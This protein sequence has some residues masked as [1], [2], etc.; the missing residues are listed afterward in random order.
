MSSV[1]AHKVML[2]CLAMVLSMLLLIC[3]CSSTSQKKDEPET[4]PVAEAQKEESPLYYDFGD[5]PVP[6]ELKLVTKS[7]FVY[8]TQGF[9][10]GVIVLKGRV[11]LGSLIEF[12]ENNMAKDNWQVVSTFKSTRTLL[13]FQKE[14]RWCVINITD[15]TYNT[16]V[17]IWVAPTTNPID[18]GLLK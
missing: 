1:K 18:S 10:A 13:L 5:V 4:Q 2:C 3:G 17:E 11:E 8:R 12:F 15:E 9:S 7:S 14:N 16:H 6:P